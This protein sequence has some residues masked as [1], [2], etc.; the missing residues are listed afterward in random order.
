MCAAE[1]IFLRIR[2][3]L[4]KKFRREAGLAANLPATNGVVGSSNGV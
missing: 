1:H 4:Y 3:E 2:T